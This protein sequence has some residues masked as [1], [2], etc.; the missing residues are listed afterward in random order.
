MPVVSR[1]HASSGRSSSRNAIRQPQPNDWPPFNSVIA[2]VP[3]A[4]INPAMN[5]P[6][7]LMH[8]W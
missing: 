5:G 1:T 4:S 3:S 8:R 7:S 2:N 6:S